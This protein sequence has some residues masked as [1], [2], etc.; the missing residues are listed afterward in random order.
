MVY[1]KQRLLTAAVALC[2]LLV[3]LLCLNTIYVNIIMA[4]ICMIAMYEILGALQLRGQRLLMALSILVSGAVALCNLLQP[5]PWLLPA[6]LLYGGVL[7]V[8]LLKNHE[9]LRYEKLGFVYLFSLLM[10]FCLN[11]TLY[12]REVQGITVSVFYTLLALGGAWF[13]DTG[14]YF[15]GRFF[16]KH[17]LAPKISPN[18]TVEGLFGGI[19]FCVLTYLLIAAIFDGVCAYIGV[20]TAVDYLRLLLIAPLVALVGALGDLSASVVKRQCALKDFGNILPGHG[21]ILDRFDSV[22]FVAPFLYLVSVYLPI[23]SVY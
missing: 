18:K 3:A 4:V 5:Q 1:L 21:G 11:L 20:E 8:I 12:L 7:F 6:V 17:K 16:G 23:L 2:V 13:S 9:T 19:L 14:G 15:V 10:P 22:L